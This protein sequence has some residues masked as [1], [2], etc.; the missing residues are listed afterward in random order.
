MLAG[1]QCALFSAAQCIGTFG[2][3]MIVLDPSYVTY[4]ATIRACGAEI[5]R[6][7]PREDGS[8]R[9]DSRAI[10]AAITSRTRAIFFASPNNPTG[11]AYNQAELE[12]IAELARQHN[13]WVVS[14]EVYADLLF[15]GEHLSIAGLPGMSERTATISSLSKSHAMAGWRS[16]WVIAPV[17]FIKHLSNL[18]LCMLYGLPGFVQEAAVCAL[19][20]SAAEVAQMRKVY[21]RR[22]ELVIGL[23]S[24]QLGDICRIPQAGMF[25][26][27]DIRGTSMNGSEFCRALYRDCG[28]SVLDASAFGASAVGF[29]RLSFT[30]DEAR[31]A[32]G[33]RRIINFIKRHRSRGV[34][35]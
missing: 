33:C 22:P 30:L 34:T 5:V 26:L 24:E 13:L 12:D 31:L 14:D 4:E 9:P 7:P 27:M 15:E 17:E 3:E 6:A 32:E 2:D 10:A 1:A 11:V 29:V 20:D 23:V 25:L 8:F 21:R 19:R 18:S 28:V 16:G 35:P